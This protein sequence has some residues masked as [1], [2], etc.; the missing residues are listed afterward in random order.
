MTPEERS[1]LIRAARQVR[2][3][4]YAPYSRFSVGAAVLTESGRVYTGV[5]VECS[6]YPVGL[7]AERS[8]LATA[9]S[10]GDQSFVG[11]AVVTELEPPAAPCG[12]CRQALAEFGHSMTVL[13]ASPAP[14]S[15]VVETVLSD[16]L[17]RYFEGSVLRRD[18][19]E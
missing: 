3:R 8:A 4:A 16:L 19:S 1:E 18:E 17:P 6:S 11:I 15:P 9:V 2:A 7:C 12:M 5:N 10:S 13:L 14:G